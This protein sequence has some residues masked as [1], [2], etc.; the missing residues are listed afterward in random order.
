MVLIFVLIAI[1]ISRKA[2]TTIY[3]VSWHSLEQEYL[4]FLYPKLITAVVMTL[5]NNLNHCVMVLH[6]LYSDSTNDYTNAMKFV[7]HFLK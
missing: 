2:R 5:E 6:Q 1:E 4:L 7:P 3:Y